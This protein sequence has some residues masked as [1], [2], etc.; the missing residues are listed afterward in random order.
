MIQST[1]A[2]S[3][4]TGSLTVPTVQELSTPVAQGLEC[5]NLELTIC[6]W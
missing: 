5:L 2:H 4:V 1:Y 3:D 6:H